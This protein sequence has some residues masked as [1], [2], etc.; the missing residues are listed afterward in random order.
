M[1]LGWP[2]PGLSL[3]NTQSGEQYVQWTVGPVSSR[4]GGVVGTLEW[5]K[6]GLS[7]LSTQVQSS[8][9]LGQGAQ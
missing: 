3:L 7:L 4:T 2:K 8:V 9:Y 1:D 6:P 5:P